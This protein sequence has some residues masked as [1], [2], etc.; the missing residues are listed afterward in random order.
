MSWLRIFFCISLPFPCLPAYAG[1][2]PALEG[3]AAAGYL[4]VDQTSSTYGVRPAVRD[5]GTA[6]LTLT[7]RADAGLTRP[8]P[9]PADLAGLLPR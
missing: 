4:H 1:E 7:G 8:M 3:D 2:A 9:V 5:Y 6:A